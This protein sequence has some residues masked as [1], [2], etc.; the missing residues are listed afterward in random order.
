MAYTIP[1]N[2][3][4]CHVDVAVDPQTGKA[5]FGAVICSIT[6]DFIAAKNDPLR[7]TIDPHT[8]EAMAVKEA[9]SWMKNEAWTNIRV[10]MDCLN[11][12]NF[13]NVPTQ[14]FSYAGAIISSC[15]SLAR[16]FKKGLVW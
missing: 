6:N 9:L 14:D 7:Y 16:Q 13:L 8:A 11:G 15:R 1:E 12:C 2:N 3:V 10:E 4:V 5:Y